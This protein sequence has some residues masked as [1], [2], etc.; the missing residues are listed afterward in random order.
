[1][2]VIVN[3][4]ASEL[5]P[6]GEMAVGLG[7]PYSSGRAAWPKCRDRDHYESA[8]EAEFQVSVGVL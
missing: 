7:P 1:L 3:V 6:A 8:P 5:I 4:G 2:K